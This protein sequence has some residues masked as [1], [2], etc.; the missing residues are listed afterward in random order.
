MTPGLKAWAEEWYEHAR[1]AF[2]RGY[3]A[4]ASEAP[5]SPRSQQEFHLLLDA[6]LLD[7]ALY[8]L[9]YELNNRPD[10]VAL[11]LTGILQCMDASTATGDR[12]MWTDRKDNTGAS[13]RRSR[14]EVNQ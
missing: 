1:T 8:E 10:W 7:K 3:L 13:V 11:P 12:E 2:L 4:I 9:T 14:D 6:H 5:F